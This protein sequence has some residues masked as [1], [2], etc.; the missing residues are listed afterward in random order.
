MINNFKLIIT[1]IIIHIALFIEERAKSLFKLIVIG[2]I[3]NIKI[4]F[5]N[6]TAINK[7]VFIFKFIKIINGISFCTE[8]N[9][10]KIF[11]EEVFRMEINQVWNGAMPNFINI[12]ITIIT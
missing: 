6:T 12:L 9:K 4:I 5:N 7:L 2:N 8:D 3:N 10:T 1:L 11:N